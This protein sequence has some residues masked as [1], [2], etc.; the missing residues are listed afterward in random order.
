VYESQPDLTGTGSKGID[1]ALDEA[2]LNP[3]FHIVRPA[4][5]VVKEAMVPLEPE[6]ILG[7]TMTVSLRRTGGFE[8]GDLARDAE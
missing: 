2:N 1:H 4:P 8:L 5:G 3:E 7:R 6:H